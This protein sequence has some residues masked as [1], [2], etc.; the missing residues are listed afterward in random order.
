MIRINLLPI[1]Q[2]KQRIKLRNEIFALIGIIFLACG[3]V[4]VVAHLQVTKIKAL[5]VRVSQLQQEKQK[6]QK[7]IAKINKIK[8]EQKILET[9]LQVIEELKVNSQ[10]TVRVLDEIAKLTPSNRMWLKSL[11]LTPNGMQVAAIAMDN[12]TIAQYMNKV[13]SSAF[14]S[15]PELGSSSMTKVANQ[16]FK[17]F[18]LTIAINQPEPVAPPTQQK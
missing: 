6:F 17:S 4:A 15:N 3:A 8:R 12:E 16:K 2:I 7:V 18:S 10:M 13:D 11:S 1:R 14:F 5:N 9:K